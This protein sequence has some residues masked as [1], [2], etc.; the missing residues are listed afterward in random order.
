MVPTITLTENCL[1]GLSSAETVRRKSLEAKFSTSTATSVPKVCCEVIVVGLGAGTDFDTTMKAFPVK[2][3]LDFDIK[4][5]EGLTIRCRRKSSLIGTSAAFTT[6]P[7]ESDAMQDT[8]IRESSATSPKKLIRA[9]H[10]SP[11]PSDAPIFFRQVTSTFSCPCTSSRTSS[12]F[13]LK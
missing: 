2:E 5:V 6:F 10:D 11:E 9:V 3:P 4:T 7:F 1:L 8:W 13:A 12:H